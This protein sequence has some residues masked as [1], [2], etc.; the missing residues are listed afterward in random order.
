MNEMRE[1]AADRSPS[2]GMRNRGEEEEV[3]WISFNKV[4]PFLILSTIVF[5]L[6]SLSHQIMSLA[7]A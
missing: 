5:A 2:R 3:F 1:F 4:F 6:N 7:F